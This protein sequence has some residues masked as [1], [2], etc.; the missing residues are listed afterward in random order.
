MS[1][2]TLREQLQGIPGAERLVMDYEGGGKTQVF[3]IDETKVRLGPNA[4]AEEIKA[5]LHEVMK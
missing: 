2:F 4:T 3:S 1:I 5:A